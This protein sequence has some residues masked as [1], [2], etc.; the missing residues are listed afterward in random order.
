MNL[1]HFRHER[2]SPNRAGGGFVGMRLAA[3][4][5]T[6]GALAQRC[7]LCQRATEAELR[8]C[9]METTAEKPSFSSSA[10]G[11]D[12]INHSN[13]SSLPFCTNPHWTGKPFCL[14]RHYRE[15]CIDFR[16]ETD[17]DGG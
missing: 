8:C 4:S 9:Y 5:V 10:Q 14:E 3:K 15:K 13:S 7:A 12:I 16:R 1:N 6:E 17:G 11:G 2:A